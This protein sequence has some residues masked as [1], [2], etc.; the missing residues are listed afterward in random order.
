MLYNINPPRYNPQQYY[1]TNGSYT[2]PDEH[3]VGNTTC[4]EAYISPNNNIHISQKD[5][6]DYPTYH[7]RNYTLYSL[8]SPQRKTNRKTPSTYLPQAQQQIPH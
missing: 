7:T 8:P 6:P 3:G 4:L 1:Y 5:S 2:P